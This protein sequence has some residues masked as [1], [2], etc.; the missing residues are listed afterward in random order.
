MTRTGAAIA[1]W[2]VA[3]SAQAE[4]ARQPLALRH[5]RLIGEIALALLATIAVILLS[6]NTILRLIE[7]RDQHL[8]LSLEKM[9]ATAS[10]VA[11]RL[12]ARMAARASDADV[13]KAQRLLVEA[14][15]SQN[16]PSATLIGLTDRSGRI[17]ASFGLRRVA[18]KLADIIGADHV[19]A[20][21]AGAL[22]M[23]TP[24]G[25]D[26]IVAIRDLREPF[27]QMVMVAPTS[28]FLALWRDHA[29]QLARLA[30]AT[31]LVMALLAAAL[32]WQRR[33]AHLALHESDKARLRM[34]A[35][36]DDIWLVERE[37][38]EKEEALADARFHLKRSRL[39]IT[40]QAAELASVGGRWE[41]E[42]LRAE[43]A[44][45]TKS[46]FLANMSHELRTPLNAIIGFSEIM[47]SGLFGALGSAK[48]DEYVSNIRRSGQYL[49]AVFSDILEMSC[50]EA[51]R[52]RIERRVVQLKE[53]IGEAA[54]SVAGAA[55]AKR[56]N[57]T[58][59]APAFGDVEVDAPALVKV[60]VHLARNAINHTP[61]GGNVTIR[62]KL[63]PRHV[64]IHIGD[65]GI[66]IPRR[67]LHDLGRPFQRVDSDASKP[68]PGSGLGLAIARAIV[69]L[70]GGRLRI[71]SREG[72][73][74]VVG[75]SLPR[76]RSA[77]AF[78]AYDQPIVDRGH[79]LAQLRDGAG[80]S[81]A[82]REAEMTRDIA[83][84]R[85]V[86]PVEA[87]GFG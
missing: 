25:V 74:T 12:N 6:V 57:L 17:V 38:R 27:G 34:Q 42:R 8:A 39:A 72:S 79:L 76:G 9:D 85:R 56:L 1:R 67:R 28:Y 51:G 59:D 13:G 30:G 45:R 82:R 78:S 46:E 24:D 71:R 52:R 7:V 35:A 81:G 2:R 83:Q 5:K 31:V 44:N 33:R 60:L 55:E 70:H 32:F 62:A 77:P 22:R 73:G 86:V 43:D 3:A 75:L 20:A 66:G 69:E 19:A 48:Y 63:Y 47:E 16:Q 14:M 23:M 37:L 54:V 29:R 40:R 65:S 49:L 26:S 80:E 18:D 87:R 10:L 21:R 84:N 36:L 15:P 11:E 53:V 58:I 41:H 68:C 50:I 64:G 61:E 4:R